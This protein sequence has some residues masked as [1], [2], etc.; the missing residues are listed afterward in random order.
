MIAKRSVARNAAVEQAGCVRL[1]QARARAW[2]FGGKCIALVRSVCGHVFGYVRYGS[3]GMF[4]ASLCWGSVALSSVES[5][6]GGEQHRNDLVVLALDA[7]AQRA[8]VR[9]EGN[10]LVVI[11]KGDLV[12]GSSMRVTAVR[13]DRVEVESPL[14]G[15]RQQ[16]AWYISGAD[17]NTQVVTLDTSPQAIN[18]QLNPAHEGVPMVGVRR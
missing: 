10:R 2:N 3:T 11:S 18:G 16:R 7:I 14:P 8:V 5:A 15:G 12:P 9:L 1:R 13:T 6:L 4:W 17:G